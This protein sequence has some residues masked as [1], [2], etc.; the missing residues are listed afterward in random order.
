MNISRGAWAARTFAY[1]AAYNA[2]ARAAPRAAMLVQRVTGDTGRGRGKGGAAGADYFEAVASDYETIARASGVGEKL[3]AGKR[4][5]ELGPGDTRAIALLARLA[6]AESWEGLDAFDIQSRDRRY[7]EEIYDCILAR[8][9]ERRGSCELLEGC[10]MHTSLDSLA[11]GG[12]R[13]DV[14]VSRAVLEHVR[15][16]GALFAAVARVAKDDAVLV[17]KVDLRSHGIEHR[18]GLDFLRFSET[19]WRAMSSHVDLPNRVRAPA[20]LELGESVGLRTIWARTTH[21]MDAADADAIRGELAPPFRAMEARDLA[22][23]GLWLVQVGPAHP[24]ASRTRAPLGP[25]PHD[26]LSHY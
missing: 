13:F 11:R 6:G 16:L 24:L 20:Y 14:V 8:R 18:H 22:V 25:S 17:H 21:V 7:V 15:D 19:T 26:D 23:L 2:F 4:V 3:F 12:R 5:L 1:H 9:G 10:R